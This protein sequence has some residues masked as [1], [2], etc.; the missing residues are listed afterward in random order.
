MIFLLSNNK[1]QSMT[2]G[3]KNPQESINRGISSNQN[4]ESLLRKT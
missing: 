3:T 4:G 2:N 1:C